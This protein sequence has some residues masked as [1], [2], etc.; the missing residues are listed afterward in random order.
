MKTKRTIQEVLDARTGEE[1]IADDFFKK[2]L[3]EII[4][5]RSDLQKA[6]ENII[7]P[8]FV[9]FYCKQ[10]IRIRGGKS[11]S[12][13]RKIETLHFAHLKDS[14]ACHIKTANPYTKEEVDRI[15]YNRSKESQLHLVTKDKLIQCLRFNERT[16][17]EISDIQLEKVIKAKGPETEWKKPDINFIFKDKRVALDLQLSTT[18]LDVVTRRQ[19]F[20]KNQGIYILWVFHYFDLNDNTRRLMFNDVVYTNNQNAYVFDDEAFEKSIKEK[21]LFL[22]CFYKTYKVRNLKLEDEWPAWRFINIGDM[23]F[24]E[25]YHKI[26]YHDSNGEKESCLQKLAEEIQEQAKNKANVRDEYYRIKTGKWDNSQKKKKLSEKQGGLDRNISSLTRSVTNL[27]S[28]LEHTRNRLDEIDSYTQS[29]FSY[30]AQHKEDAYNFSFSSLGKP[31][32]PFS[33]MTEIQKKYRVWISDNF[34]SNNN[35]GKSIK[36]ISEKRVNVGSLPLYEQSNGPSL[37]ILNPAIK[38]HRDFIER[39]WREVKMLL[40]D[41]VNSLFQKLQPIVS[42]Y[43]LSQIIMNPTWY[44]MF[45]FNQYKSELDADYEKFQADLTLGQVKKERLLESLQSEVKDFLETL[46]ITTEKEFIEE[47]LRLERANEESSSFEK[48]LKA[49]EA[50]RVVLDKRY[51]RNQVLIRE[52]KIT[53]LEYEEADEYDQYD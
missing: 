53:G 3:D 51:S 48:G 43:N 27:E 47:N 44:F 28:Q 30:L 33:L 5:V 40:K 15:K 26:F 17:G 19:E 25:E 38:S 34:S 37:R 39:N 14:E 7:D 12:V 23:T 22:K 52:L 13:G 31:P 49:L 18:W 46:I 32:F 36:E 9:C 1:I 4:V 35:L 10:R 45:D 21:N 6:I 20:Y 8:V 2:P 16:I 11:D 50:E 42:V 29:I 24:E 41:D